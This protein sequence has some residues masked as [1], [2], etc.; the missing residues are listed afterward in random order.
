MTYGSQV[1]YDGKAEDPAG[2]HSLG[3]ATWPNS[4]TCSGMSGRDAGPVEGSNEELTTT[5]PGLSKAAAGRGCGSQPALLGGSPLINSLRRHPEGCCAA[6]GL[7]YRV[8]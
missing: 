6:G 8:P 3:I 4:T 2:K 1:Y 5:C 7:E